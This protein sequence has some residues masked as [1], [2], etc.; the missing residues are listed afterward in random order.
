[1]HN[2]NFDAVDNGGQLQRGGARL[3]RIDT[4][5]HPKISK[6]FALNPAAVTRMIEMARRV[7]LDGLALTEHFHA[8]AYWEVHQHLAATFPERGGVFWAGDLALIPGAEVNIREGAHVI[9]LGEVSEL[10]RLDESFPRRLSEHYEPTLREFL[11][12]T[13]DFEIARIGAHMFRRSKELGK[14]AAADLKR[15]HALEINGKDFGTEVMLLAQA[16]ALNL[17]IVG[18]SDAHHWLQTG[19]RHTLMHVDDVSITS[20]LKAIKEGLTGFSTA[21]YTPLRVKTAKSLKTITKLLRKYYGG[22]VTPG[23]SLVTAR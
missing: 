8:T 19:V 12:V 22:L 3:K 11:D 15:L 20:I 16:R 9:V 1:L 21:P 2:R 7:G 6:H 13:D 10:R 18:G 23:R 17:P 4:H 14:F 5:S